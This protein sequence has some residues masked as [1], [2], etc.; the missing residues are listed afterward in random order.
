[1]TRSLLPLITIAIS[2][3]FVSAEA[4][5]L[6]ERRQA[7]ARKNATAMLLGENEGSAQSPEDEYNDLH[8]RI[9]KLIEEILRSSLDVKT[10]QPSPFQKPQ[11]P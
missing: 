7:E 3:I 5:T 8:H 11:Q 9:Q 10:L 4:E 1:M 2:S 6:E